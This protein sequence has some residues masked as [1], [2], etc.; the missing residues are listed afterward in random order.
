MHRKH[1]RPADVT[2]SDVP[3]TTTAPSTQ[4][5]FPTKLVHRRPFRMLWHRILCVVTLVK[6]NGLPSRSSGN[7]QWVQSLSRRT[8][9][10]ANIFAPY[11]GEGDGSAA[12]SAVSTSEIGNPTA[13]SGASH[14]DTHPL[15]PL[16]YFPGWISGY[17]NRTIIRT[18]R[19]GKWMA[20]W[21]SS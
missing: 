12:S 11:H 13:R 16:L 5:T 6:P 8:T 17:S 10:V 9:G 3:A 19:S 18:N 7:L 1:C 21:I 2:V 4:P 15:D 14:S 20:L